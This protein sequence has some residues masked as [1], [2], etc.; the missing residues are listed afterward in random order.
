MSALINAALSHARTVLMTLFLIF[1]AGIVAFV[2]IA[3][4]SMPDVNIPYINV[5]VTHRGISPEDAVRLLI[6]PLEQ[7][8]RSIEGTK[9]MT[10]K[11]FEGGANVTLEFEAGFDSDQALDDVREKVDDAKPELPADSDDPVVEEF[12]VS[13]FPIM[14]VTLSGEVPERALL[15]IS[16]ELQDEI[17]A[18]PE[19]LEVN[20]A[21]DRDEQAEV[22]INPAMVDSYGIS[23][24]QLSSFLATSNLLVAAGNLDTGKGR[25]SIKVPGLLENVEDIMALPIQVSGD[26]AV[27]LEH[28]ATGRKTF[29]DATSYARIDGK[30]S[31]A[32]EIKKR[33]GQNVIKTVEKSIAI[34]EA[35]KKKWPKGLNVKVDYT[36]DQSVQIKDMLSDLQNNVIAAVL[37]VMIMVIAFLGVR[38]GFLVGMA[39]PGSFLMAILVLYSV[40]FT[41][42]MMVL[43][44]LILAVGMLVDGA[45]V[46]TEYADR[47]MIEGMGKKKAYAEASKRM[48][49]PVIASTAT[50]LAAFLPLA[51]WPGVVGE[52][53]KYL[54]LTLMATLIA[55]LLMALIFIPTLGSL[56]GKAGAVDEKA[57]EVIVASEKGDVLSLKGF[58]GTYA[59]ILKAALD[60]S[61]KVIL[62]AVW[63]LIAAF[64][65][66]GRYGKGIEFF[67]EVEPEMASIQIHARGNLSIN[68]KDALVKEVEDRIIGLDE[69]KTVFTCSGC[70]SGDSAEDV[71][72]YIQLELKDWDERR[73][74]EKIRKDI[75]ERTKDLAGVIVEARE[76]EGGPSQG[77]P[78][79]VEIASL[80]DNKFE[81]AV[82]HVRKGMDK[83]GGLVDIE[84]SRPLPG[85]QWELKVDRIQAAK[86]GLDVSSVGSVVKLVTQGIVFS[87]YRPDDSDEELDIVARYP[88]EYRSLDQ[89]GRI[90]VASQTGSSVPASSF[91]KMTPKPAVS[92]INRTDGKRVMTIKSDVAAGVLVNDKV[93][94][95]QKWLEENPL[96]SGIEYKFRGED[97]DQ[98]EAQE[99][100]VK[101]FVVAL[102]IMAIILVTQFNSFYSAFLILSA[103]IMS[104]I[105]VLLGLLVTGQA[106]GIVMGGIGVISLAGIVV[107]N[108]IVL[109]DTHDVLK[110]RYADP[111]E[112]ILRTGVQ[113][114][115]P[116][117]LTTA[118]TILGLLP[119]VLTLN[120]D[121]FH[122]GY[123]FGAPSM[124]WW[125]QLST[126][127]V[128]GLTFA[129]I[130][131]LV[132]TPCSLMMRARVEKD[133][134]GFFFFWR[135]FK[136]KSSADIDERT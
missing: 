92:M 83:I 35:A 58:T 91:M 38:T 26:S 51:F 127:V 66:Y 68:E 59:R 33:T 14:V 73:P 131:T 93:V 50:T 128:F 74:F 1:V 122:R 63:L 47:K 80:D 115:R 77:K 42:N 27:R 119:M 3:K 100:L 134:K 85:V 98:R 43:F 102:F 107:N 116:V 89:L 135:R 18:L 36:Q 88:E 30:P 111:M 8:L 118:T 129:T 90:R 53:M 76:Q 54:P 95:L 20:I 61:G 31:I 109:I 126:A 99:F 110:H 114:L 15:K 121:F 45:I 117:L 130:L 101:A 40:G 69:Y 52:F 67:P 49:W 55:S 10:A 82:A 6:K 7:E 16:R 104:T 12:N 22:I 94:E 44:A 46:I 64:N 123:S 28:I 41:L 103:V 105:G 87:S 57:M 84:D 133:P 136:A 60:N 65:V 97:E 72:G 48:A 56:F 5:T 34:I 71:I 11:A 120:I 96:P 86:F 62:F 29:E 39:I 2:E 132:V 78:V 21:G 13:L 24:Y 37:L 9:E 112:A 75:E 32:L 113:R 17:E 79:V 125:V 19:V 81:G 70:S 124:Q 108:N 4:E 23:S 106:F 25:F